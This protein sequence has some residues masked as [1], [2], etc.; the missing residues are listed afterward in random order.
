MRDRQDLG[1][2]PAKGRHIKPDELLVLHLA[3]TTR[4]ALAQT[5]PGAVRPGPID[6]SV[7]PGTGKPGVPEPVGAYVPHGTAHT[8]P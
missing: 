8:L 7:Q 5:L 1:K 2:Q 3:C 4:M 6:S